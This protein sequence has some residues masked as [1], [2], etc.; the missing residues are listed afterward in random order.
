MLEGLVREDLTL[1]DKSDRSERAS[2]VNS[3][4]EENFQAEGKAS[5]KTLRQGQ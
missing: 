1:K 3:Y 4:L 5:I 2:H